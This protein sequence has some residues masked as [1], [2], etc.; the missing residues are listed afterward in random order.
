MCHMLN[1]T[2]LTF[3]HLIPKSVPVA[4]QAV[5]E[6]LDPVHELGRGLF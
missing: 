4:L 5:A 1:D 3:P 2:I 6:M